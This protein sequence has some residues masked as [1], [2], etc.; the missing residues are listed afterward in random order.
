MPYLYSGISI[1]LLVL[2]NLFYLE[3]KTSFLSGTELNNKKG[4]SLLFDGLQALLMYIMYI[5]IYIHIGGS[6]AYSDLFLSFLIGYFTTMLTCIAVS[7]KKNKDST[8]HAIT[9]E[10]SVFN[11][12]ALLVFS[13]NFLH[14]PYVAFVILGIMAVIFLLHTSYNKDQDLRFK[15]WYVY[16]SSLLGIHLIGE[17]SL[18]NVLTL[19]TFDL[20]PVIQLGTF[21]Y[22]LY[23]L[24][25]SG[26]AESHKSTNIIGVYFVY[27]TCILSNNLS[28]IIE[29]Y[30]YY[31]NLYTT[32][33]F[34]SV[35]LAF[36]YLFSKHQKL[37]VNEFKY[38]YL[39]GFIINN[40]LSLDY[41]VSASYNNE[42]NLIASSIGLLIIILTLKNIYGFMSTKYYWV[43]SGLVFV[44]F[45]TYMNTFP[46]LKENDL[47]YSVLAILMAIV[48]NYFGNSK[49]NKG[50]LNSS[51]V[52]ILGFTLKIIFADIDI[53]NQ[54]NILIQVALLFILAFVFLYVGLYYRNKNSKKVDK[55]DGD[56]NEI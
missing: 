33:S 14:K 18:T 43:L 26:L 49:E 3:L 32:L 8:N 34:A 29:P 7:Y 45:L 36:T 51:I 30:F 41:L 50:L 16:I 6:F 42:L 27:A 4:N 46:I 54:E 22:V 53:F 2:L 52:Y 23:K 9:S 48:I 24:L 38:V 19:G 13:G 31:G 35:S 11:L 37:R 1:T 28:D 17:A 20:I 56:S 39:F 21:L 40:M 47:L 44:E 15:E 12:I 5:V 10:F 55:E 25:T